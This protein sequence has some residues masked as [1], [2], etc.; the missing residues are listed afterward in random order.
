[1]CMHNETEIYLN[2]LRT[3]TASCLNIIK[4]WHF[5][6]SFLSLLA[7]PNQLKQNNHGQ[8]HREGLIM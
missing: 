8:V 4:G 2:T 3:T 6:F 1:M 5:S 7:L